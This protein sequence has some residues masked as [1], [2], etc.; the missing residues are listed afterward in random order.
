MFRTVIASFVAFLILVESAVPT[1][2]QAIRDLRTRAT[3]T[4]IGKVRKEV[5]PKDN[6]ERVLFLSPGGP[7][8]M[9]LQIFLNGKPFRM[10]REKLVD[11]QLALVD[12]NKDGKKSWEEALRNPRFAYGRLGT[13]FRANNQTF[14]KT[15]IARYDVNK[16]GLVD[17]FEMRR[18]FSQIGYG[19]AFQVT[20][21]FAR[22]RLPDIKKLL[23]VNGDGKLSP[24][25]LKAVGDRLK[26]RDADDNDV[27]ELTELGGATT[28]SQIQIG[29]GFGRGY[30]LPSSGNDA[31]HL[32]PEV[33]LSALYS[34]MRSKYV[35]GQ[36]KLPASIFRFF[37]KM[38]KSLDLNKNGFLDPGETVGFHLAKPQVRLRVSIG[39][40]KSSEAALK[41]L[42][43]S[44]PIK[45]S[46]SSQEPSKS[47]LAISLPGWKLRLQV[48]DVTTPKVDYTRTAQLTLSRYDKN[49]NGYL[50][51][52]EMSGNPYILSQFQV[53]DANNDGKVYA[54]E[55]KAYYDQLQIP[56]QSQISLVTASQAPSLFG[57]IDANGDHRISLRE[58]RTAESRLKAIDKNRNGKIEPEEM[59]QESTITLAQGRNYYSYAY[60]SPY[61]SPSNRS[62]RRGPKWFLHMDK[63]GDGDVTLREFLGKKEIFKKLDRNGDGFIEVKE[64]EAARQVSSKGK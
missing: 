13:A 46:K 4:T 64:A 23:D 61:Q 1:N 31:Y 21:N 26:S 20:R 12:T 22:S 5:N 24:E 35:T 8:V 37:P 62:A 32:G 25:E 27:L 59:P 42:S 41:V 53:W 11:E 50:E 39:K 57:A 40:R 45:I 33:N 36:N 28:R 49:K 19:R 17:R 54:D 43:V 2:A 56:Q 34:A 9:E 38:F 29:S 48:P 63:N 7:V 30:R 52:E 6:V 58:M 16:D 14:L 44:A 15:M 55:I 47:H 51:K 18:L 10:F 3:Q 60:R